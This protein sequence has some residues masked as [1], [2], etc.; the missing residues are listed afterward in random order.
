MIRNVNSS[1]DFEEDENEDGSGYEHLLRFSL[2]EMIWNL[3]P[4]ESGI[5]ISCVKAVLR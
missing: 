1:S 3:M 2:A 5:V 4:V